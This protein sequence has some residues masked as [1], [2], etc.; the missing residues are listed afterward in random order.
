M[1]K[2]SALRLGHISDLHLLHLAGVPLRA[3]ASKRVTGLAN[4]ALGRRG[5]HSRAIADALPAALAKA[6]VDHVAITGDLTNLSLDG[7]FQCARDLVEAIGGP[8]RVTLIPGNH[9]VYTRGALRSG[10]FERWF[11]PWLVE[12][13]ADPSAI[14]SAVAAGRGAWPVIRDV[15][16]HVRIYALSSGVPTGPLVAQGVIG[17]TQLARM[18][19]AR[20]DEPASVRHRIVLLHHNLHRR[21]PLHERTAQLVDRPRLVAALR[22]MGATLI[23]HGHSH[24]PNQHHLMAPAP[25][26][27]EGR[28]IPVLGCGSSTWNRPD[29]SHFA[30]FNTIDLDTEGGITARAFVWQPDRGA[31]VPERDD[32]VERALDSRLPW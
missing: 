32:L 30:H 6:G 12:A 10:R 8:E 15:N 16:E 29:R 4:L 23:L 13:G 17:S 18:A 7:E 2:H 19:A 1:G 5:A 31:F 27:E 24:D 9:D 14:D 3:W 21:S 22:R 25:D 28:A 20:A 11:G 26:G